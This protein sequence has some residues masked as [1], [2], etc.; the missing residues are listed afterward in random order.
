MMVTRKDVILDVKNLRIHYETPKG[1][2]IAVN[3]INFQ[4]YKGEIVGL[5]GESG[6]GK[7]TAAMGILQLIQAP[8]RI[9]GGETL[10][11]GTNL[12]ALNEDELRL[13]R[14]RELALIP[15]GAMNS[16]NPVMR[17][18]DQIADAIK[19]HEGRQSKA[20]LK[21][22]ILE[23]FALVGLPSRVYNLYPHELSGGMKQRVCIAMAIVLN[24]PLIIADEPT[25]ALDV[26]VQRV[27]AQTLLDVKNR[28]GVSMIMIG[29]DM[30]LQA[31]L[32]DRIIIMYAGNIVEV[33]PVSRAFENPLH[34]YTQLLIA[35][36]P[37]IKE[38]KPL[39]ITEGLTH[40]LRNPPPGCIFQFRCQH[41]G[42]DCRKNAAPTMLEVEP[43]HFVACHLYAQGRQE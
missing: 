36:I 42:E 20:A 23:V 43:D 30:A 1:D 11:N 17:V 14:W 9:I 38:R 22:R 26:V 28:L 16:L 25:S 2:V 29:H 41:V 13:R 40:D 35:S 3:G 18:R 34:P 6:C 27:V 32:V 8:G 12:L 15:Q 21:Q 37:S 19:T 10:I 39:K 33:T 24:P 7:T 5:V 31:Q 4:V